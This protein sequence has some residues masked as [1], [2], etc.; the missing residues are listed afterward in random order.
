MSGS[1]RGD[2]LRAF[3]RLGI[4]AD[5]HLLRDHVARTLGMEWGPAA[6]ASVPATVADVLPPGGA[7]V[8][9]AH[10]AMSTSEEP[11][12]S[13]ATVE[14]PVDPVP[15]AFS[16]ARVRSAE[17]RFPA[18]MNGAEPLRLAAAD[19]AA[20]PPTP[21]PLLDP[22]QA[23]AVLSGALARRLPDGPIDIESVLERIARGEVVA[24]LP[25]TAVPSIARGVQLL[26]D[27]GDG[28]APYAADVVWIREALQRVV[29][30]YALE[31]LQFAHAPL[32]GAGP[33][34]RRTWRPYAELTQ[35]RRGATIVAVTDLGLRRLEPPAQ[36]AAVEEWTA[37]A[38]HLDRQGCPLLALV[39]YARYRVPA[40]LR[41]R[42]AIVEWDRRT[43]AG[44]VRA[45]IARGLP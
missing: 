18:W 33:K 26:I 42:F 23:R 38:D 13:A 14:P 22:T 8:P 19:T 20:T 44:R 24:E 10:R 2:V 27:R 37:L 25:R 9:P 30:G 32:R 41:R 43:T 31:V 11:R 4:A 7:P 16:L 36:P 17:R 3:H 21:V 15:E 28:M 5:D 34:S 40:A 45:L 35:P 12:R 1:R 29:G 6:H 39:P